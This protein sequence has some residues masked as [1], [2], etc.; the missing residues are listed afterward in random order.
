MPLYILK[1]QQRGGI[2]ETDTA[3]V[4]SY[5]EEIIAHGDDLFY[6]S[7]KRGET[8][9]RFNQVAEIIA[10]FSFAPGGVTVFGL[11]FEAHQP[12][13]GSEHTSHSEASRGEEDEH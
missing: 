9:K 8:A 6:R 13:S 1:F 2:T 3:R 5:L 11:H 10:V 7:K 4:Y 12:L